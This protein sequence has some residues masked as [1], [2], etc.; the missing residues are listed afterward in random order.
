[1]QSRA[2]E[3][4]Q[5]QIIEEIKEMEDKRTE[6]ALDLVMMESDLWKYKAKK[7]KQEYCMAPGN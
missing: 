4:L 1:M 2:S 3:R 6:E 7:K 5:E